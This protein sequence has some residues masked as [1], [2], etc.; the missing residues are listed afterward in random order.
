MNT[1]QDEDEFEYWSGKSDIMI[2]NQLRDQSYPY[3]FSYDFIHKKLEQISS[4]SEDF[5]IGTQ[6]ISMKVKNIDNFTKFSAQKNI[7]IA[8]SSKDTL[9]KL[10][11]FN[12]NRGRIFFSKYSDAILFFKGNSWKIV[13]SQNTLIKLKNSIS[14]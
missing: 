13:N 4:S 6:G 8:K 2:K 5:Y 9:L 11:K 1:H 12:G 7:S 14:Y 10:D 3:V